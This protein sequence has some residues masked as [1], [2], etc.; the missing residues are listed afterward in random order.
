MPI[1]LTVTVPDDAQLEMLFRYLESTGLPREEQI[2]LCQRAAQWM[3]YESNVKQYPGYRSV[4]AELSIIRGHEETQITLHH[5]LD[6]LRAS[7]CEQ[8]ETGYDPHKGE[9]AEEAA[10]DLLSQQPQE[11][12]RETKTT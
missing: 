7:I 3:N 8:A 1:I 9:L 10:N 2:R 4:S 12:R 5:L 11:G 6:Q